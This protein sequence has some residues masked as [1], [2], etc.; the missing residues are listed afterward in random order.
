MEMGF[1]PHPFLEHFVFLSLP[2]ANHS[3][4]TGLYANHDVNRG[5]Y[6]FHALYRVLYANNIVYKCCIRRLVC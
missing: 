4:Y 5:C 2:Y 6:G 3:V 1:D